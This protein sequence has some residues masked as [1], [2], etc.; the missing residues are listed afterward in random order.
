[1]TFAVMAVKDDQRR[2]VGTLWTDDEA[3]AQSLAPELCICSDG[4]FIKV[5]RLDDRE[6]PFRLPDKTMHFC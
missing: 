2:V 4:E 3:R 1:M 5:L 6:I